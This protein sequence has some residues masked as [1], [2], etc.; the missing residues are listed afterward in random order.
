MVEHERAQVAGHVRATAV[1]EEHP[2]PPKPGPPPLTGAQWDEVRGQWIRWVDDETGWVVVEEHPDHAVLGDPVDDV[3]LP[4]GLAH[5]LV[6][7][8][9]LDLRHDEVVIDLVAPEPTVRV[10][11]A[12]WNEIMARWER[13][14]WAANDWVE[15]APAG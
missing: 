8:H 11:G 7:S 4:A 9:D 14:D 15:A 1:V 2:R 3:V 6:V 10:P 13:W 12:Q 5:D